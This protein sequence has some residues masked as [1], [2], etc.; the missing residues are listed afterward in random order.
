ML[1][2][3]PCVKIINGP[4]SLAVVLSATFSA[5]RVCERRGLTAS[6]S[7]AMHRARHRGSGAL[8]NDG[9]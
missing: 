7:V 8:P 5:E 1:A 3:K 2:S 9:N 4:F 6:V